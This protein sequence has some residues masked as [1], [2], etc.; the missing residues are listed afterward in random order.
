MKLNIFPKIVI[1]SF[2][3]PKQRLNRNLGASS[4]SDDHIYDFAPS[5]NS[6]FLAVEH[7]ES[8]VSSEFSELGHA[9]RLLEI[10]ANSK[11]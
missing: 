7:D 6:G 11:E 5:K 4:C 3:V 9:I 2:L 1:L 8:S 10:E